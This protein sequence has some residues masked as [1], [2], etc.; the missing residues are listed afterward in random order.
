MNSTTA[1]NGIY[2]YYAQELNNMGKSGLVNPVD[3]ELK[4]IAPNY[5]AIM[6][7]A[8]WNS[9]ALWTCE[10]LHKN[11]S[12]LEAPIIY[13]LKDKD[14]I[15]LSNYDN[16]LKNGSWDYIWSDDVKASNYENKGVPAYNNSC[17]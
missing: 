14:Y 1:L 7:F 15:K 4:I 6:M 3:P 11:P 17:K 16:D 12:N 5:D 8:N 2:V 13:Y 10:I 9:S